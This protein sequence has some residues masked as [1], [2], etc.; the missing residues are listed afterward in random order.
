MNWYKKSSYTDKI[1]LTDKEE[2]I[3]SF[4]S[5]AARFYAPGISLLVVGG[6]TRD[7]LLGIESDDIDIAIS[8]MSGIEFAKIIST[9]A[10]RTGVKDVS[11]AHEISLEKS[12]EAEKDTANPQLMV[13]G[14][15]VF[16]QKIEFVPMRTETYTKD[17]RTPQIQRTDNVKE[18]VVR[19]DLTINAIY[20]NIETK[21]VEDYVGGIDDL[22][23]MTL[24]TPVDPVK[25]FQEDPL[26]ML[27]VLRFYSKFPDSTIDESVMA[28]LKNPEV[29][30]FYG[31]PKLAPERASKEFIKMME[32][33]RPSEAAR[34]M[35]ETGL[36]KKVLLPD[37]QMRDI[38]MDQMNP[39]HQY[40]VM[41]HILSVIKNTNQIAQQ[42]DM[43]QKER[44]WL[45]LAALFHDFGKLYPEVQTEHPKRPGEMQY[46]GHEDKS[47]EF[48]KKI[49]TTMGF[50]QDV[51]KFVLPVIQH[52]MWPFNFQK[53]MSKQTLDKHIGKFLH[54]VG[55]LY[56]RIVQHSHADIL[57]KGDIVEQEA[58]ELQSEKQRQI[59]TL[60]KYKEEVGDLVNKTVIDGNEI[61]SLLQ[62]AA[63]ELVK[64]NAFFDVKGK[65]VN[66]MSFA[67]DKLMEQQWL[68]SVST[69]EQAREFINKNARNWTNMWNQ[70][71][72]EQ[73]Q[74]DLSKIPPTK[75]ADASSVGSDIGLSPAMEN[76]R[77]IRT[78]EYSAI[79]PFKVGDKVRL[80]SGGLSFGQI[81][82]RV[83]KID[84]ENNTMVIDLQTGKYAGKEIRVDLLD[85]T[86]LSM[87]WEKI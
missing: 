64:R 86:K 54:Q 65:K 47:A 57:G 25:T 76:N 73:K 84:S 67:I 82:G 62:I 48:A 39:H 80:R 20:Y 8:K 9:Y 55:D 53:G 33:S 22:K 18:D 75:T 49:M 21:Q 42:S 24:K 6:W 29:Q 3:F 71:Q 23:T 41:N 1:S 13:G 74:K 56:E 45:N 77:E 72:N 78:V 79:A 43:P 4:L 68:R 7:K 40:T 16:G 10:K 52:H 44:G 38:D 87:T 12:T 59:E 81:Q 51:K 31:P 2:K 35:F 15:S 28:A 46:I 11:D 58:L 63:P 32:G 69:P 60:K 36:Y 61:K 5:E 14:V 27:R 30:A 66:Y 50:D 26:R 19:R 37:P 85:A 34:I 83:T 70:Q 17:S